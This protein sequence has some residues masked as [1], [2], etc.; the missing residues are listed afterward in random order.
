MET[1]YQILKM[2]LVPVFSLQQ[3]FAPKIAGGDFPPSGPAEPGDVAA[4]A[5]KR[6]RFQ[7]ENKRAAPYTDR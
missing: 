4:H 6:R 1:L 2:V 3:L 7:K 5:L